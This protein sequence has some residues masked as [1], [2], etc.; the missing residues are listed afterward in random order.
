[1]RVYLDSRDLI[2]LVERKAPEAT[3][4]FEEALRQG[5]SQLVYSMYNI[6]ECCAPL[7]RGGEG[8]EVM[9]SMNRLEQLPHVYVAE[10]RITMLELKEAAAAFLER[11]EYSDITLPLV[12][13]FDYVV[14]G[15][16]DPP[17][18]QYLR[19]G[20]AQVIYDLWN[21]DKSLLV[22]DPAS[23]KRLRELRASDRSRN[24]YKRHGPNFRNT[25]ARNLRL[26]GIG[27]PEDMVQP[28]SA[29]IYQNPTR[30]PAQRLEYEVY[31]KVLRNLADGGEDSDI[32]DFS[33]ISCVPYC[34]AITLDRRMRGYVAQVDL[35]IG[36]QFAAKIY[37]N[38]DEV[39]ALLQPTAA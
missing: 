27:F 31:H 34:D 11:R 2:V 13:R 33:H 24:D 9:R 26:Y 17:T 12:P 19:Y 25:V 20:L 5:S 1:M 35:S 10:T 38:V 6:I 15:F 7:V 18:M 29:W 39:E 23:A 32:P 30:C 21:T 16:E 22:G 8:S 3:A 14:S 37:R 28:L 36:T 4:H